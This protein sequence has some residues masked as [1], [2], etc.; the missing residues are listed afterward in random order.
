[1]EATRSPSVAS[2]AFLWTVIAFAFLLS[3]VTVYAL[4][5]WAKPALPPMM[6]QIIEVRPEEFAKLE[7]QCTGELAGLIGP[8]AAEEG[9]LH[10]ALSAFCT[11]NSNTEIVARMQAEQYFQHRLREEGAQ[12][13]AIGTKE[14][15]ANER[16][17]D[18]HLGLPITT[19]VPERLLRQ[20]SAILRSLDEEKDEYYRRLYGNAMNQCARILTPW[21]G[22][23]APDI[24][25][26]LRT[27][28]DFPSYSPPA[29]RA[30][31]SA[32]RVVHLQWE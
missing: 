30:P 27:R 23:Y 22:R 20:Y 6:E 7:N 1:M 31:S 32:R 13:Q 28:T 5:S 8:A 26:F 29:K 15:P 24:R 19:R 18:R 10:E 14:L 4:M 21:E 17:E 12:L 3:P 11:C 25:K 9:P 16:Y 2:R